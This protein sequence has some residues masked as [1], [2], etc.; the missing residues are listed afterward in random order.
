MDAQ[1]A[2]HV[3][4]EEECP[5]LRRRV[6]DESAVP[7]A[8][9]VCRQQGAE[10]C[11]RLP[12]EP[13]AEGGVG[14]PLEEPPVAAGECLSPPGQPEHSTDP[15]PGPAP[16]ADPGTAP[17]PVRP[18]WKR[19]LMLLLG[20]AAMVFGT[21]GAAAFLVSPYNHVHPVPQMASTVRHLVAEAGITLREPLAPAASLAGV[22]VSPAEP[23]VRERYQP[24]KKEQQLQE[25]LAFREPGQAPASAPGDAQPANASATRVS[26]VEKAPVATPASPV[27]GD[28]KIRS[29]RDEPPPG[30]VPR[31]P[32]SRPAAPS[33]EPP[34]EGTGASSASASEP[35]VAPVRPASPTEL[36]RGQEAQRTSSDATAAVV[37]SLPKPAEV[38]SSPVVR[39]P[40]PAAAGSAETAPT[41]AS[42][43]DPIRTAGELRAA[44]LVP[45]DQVQ[46]LELVTQIA[47]IVKDLRE[48]EGQLRADFGKAATENAAR[49][50]DFERRLVLAEARH[51][52]AAAREAEQSPHASPTDQVRAPE[53][54]GAGSSPATSAFGS[55][56]ATPAQPGPVQLTRAEVAS[57]GTDHGLVRRY[58]VQAASPGLALLAEIDRGGGDGAQRQVLVGDTIPGYGRIKAIGQRGTAWVV[59][60]EQGNIQ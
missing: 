15:D 44:P 46:V 31:E 33:G 17:D 28:D 40:A 1:I 36:A 37:A 60:T 48:Q 20:T 41:A 27:P 9:R 7:S 39:P 57:G 14:E 49:L 35:P 53:A 22:P 18:W 13:P 19:R 26:T 10:P 59:E 23:V 51:A 55:P 5:A 42:G 11:A 29:S 56:P 2:A 47:A 25:L 30:Y 24:K 52:V 50:A 38:T 58:R 8:E 32:G 34:V 43:A 45:R 3:P 6:P 16:D 4:L 12:G 54:H 21:V